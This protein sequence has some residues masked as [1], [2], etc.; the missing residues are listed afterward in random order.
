MELNGSGEAGN[1]LAVLG[2]DVGENGVLA[3]HNHT[4]SINNSTKL[5]TKWDEAYRRDLLG[6]VD[7]L[8]QL[9]IALLKRALEVDLLDV[10]AQR[11]LLLDEGDQTVLD[12]QADLGTILDLLRER[13]ARLDA[14]GIATDG[15]MY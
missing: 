15:A 9:E 8:G 3:L 2:E 12:L 5:G 11:S 6:Q 4:I 14:E 13:A 10:V 1:L 7:V